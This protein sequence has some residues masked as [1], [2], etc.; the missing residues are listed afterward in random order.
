MIPAYD[1][2]KSSSMLF[3]A[4][5]KRKLTE[6]VNL[7]SIAKR[8]EMSIEGVAGYLR[9]VVRFQ[10]FIGSDEITPEGWQLYVK[11]ECGSASSVARDKLALQWYCQD[12]ALPLPF[13]LIDARRQK[14]RT[15]IKVDRTAVKIK[16]N[17]PPC[18]RC[19]KKLS[20]PNR[21]DDFTKLCDSC[22]E[23]LFGRTSRHA[24]AETHKSI[25]RD[26]GLPPARTIERNAVSSTTSWRRHR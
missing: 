15:Y 8:R 19:E 22:Y 6:R 1:D 17:Y 10:I 11:K 21:G 13:E 23:Q 24:E 16:H 7:A 3:Y 20:N 5:H 2:G 4:D 9:R 14:G 26:M 12:N 25:K 18:A